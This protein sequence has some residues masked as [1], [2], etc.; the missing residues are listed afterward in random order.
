MYLYKV[1]W[2][3]R[4]NVTAYVFCM[5]PQLLSDHLS[6]RK[7]TEKPTR[8]PDRSEPN[9]SILLQ[10]AEQFRTQRQ[11]PNHAAMLF[12]KRARSSNWEDAKPMADML[13]KNRSKPNFRSSSLASQHSEYAKFMAR[14]HP[15]L[16]LTP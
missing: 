13:S 7:S 16:P 8:I 6:A 15:N 3:I 10:W 12:F 4:N 5:L 14:T 1:S 2:L 11:Q 9:R